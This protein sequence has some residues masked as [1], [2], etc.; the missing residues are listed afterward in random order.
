MKAGLRPIG[1]IKTPYQALGE[2]PRN[3]DPEGPLCELVLDRDFAPGVTGLK[4]GQK[5]LVLYWFDEVERHTLVQ[6]RHKTGREYGVFALRT[7]HR[8]NPIA[9]AVVAI[10]DILDERILVKGLDCLN[11]TPLLDIKPALSTRQTN[12]NDGEFVG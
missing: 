2:C 4:V 1:Y 10:E 12:R 8:P 7:P 6:K 9:A 5:I 11:G 3:I